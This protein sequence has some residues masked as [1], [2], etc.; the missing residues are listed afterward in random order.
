[1][2]LHISPGS[3]HA[4]AERFPAGVY[5]LVEQEDAEMRHPDL[6]DIRESEEDTGIRLFPWKERGPDFSAA[7]PGRLLH[8]RRNV[9]H[10][11]H[12][13]NK[14]LKKQPVHVTLIRMMTLFH[15]FA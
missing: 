14:V 11:F 9:S 13:S 6:V 5:Q 1:V 2:L 10:G 3:E 4:L 12:G 8:R 7:V 15:G